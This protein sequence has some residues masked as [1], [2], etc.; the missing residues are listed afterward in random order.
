MTVAKGSMVGVGGGACTVVP[1]LTVL[2]G[3]RRLEEGEGQ[4]ELQLN[5]EQT[6]LP[7]ARVM[8]VKVEGCKGTHVQTVLPDVEVLKEVDIEKEYEG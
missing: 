5:T 1:V 3:M 8:E 4:V 7:V 6:V 2:P